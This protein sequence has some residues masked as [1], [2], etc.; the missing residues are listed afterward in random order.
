MKSISCF[1]GY[2]LDDNDCCGVSL[3][4]IWTMANAVVFH[5]LLFGR[6]QALSHSTGYYSKYT[7]NNF[8]SF[9]IV[10]IQQIANVLNWDNIPGS[11]ADSGSNVWGL[12]RALKNNDEIN[13]VLHQ[14]Q[15]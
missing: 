11:N 6:H 2:H 9:Y 1:T 12:V 3:A 14:L 7:N 13:F 8:I 4:M 15:F 5:W 10:W